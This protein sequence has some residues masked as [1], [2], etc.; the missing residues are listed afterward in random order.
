MTK[1]F[2][3]K[4]IEISAPASKV[5]AVLTKP[6]F[7]SEWSGNFG[8]TGP[9]DSNWEPGAEVLWKN[10][11]GEVYV[12]GRA[13]A[14]EPDKLLRFTVRSTTPAL[15]PISGLD[16]DDLTQTY[17][18]LEHEGRTTLSIAHGDFSKLA[19]GEATLPKAT[20]VWDQVLPKI[21]DLAEQ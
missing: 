2:V 19:N 9:I 15:Q 13:L 6:E 21:K 14:V 12:Q 17:A 8:A 4:S 18:L 16:E 1:L 10:A 5:W 20:A 11:E 3:E 7:T